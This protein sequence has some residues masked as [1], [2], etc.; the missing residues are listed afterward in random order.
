MVDFFSQL[1]YNEQLPEVRHDPESTALR[2]AL[3]RWLHAPDRRDSDT[4][5]IY[6]SGHGDTQAGYF[7]L[8]TADT[9][10]REYE[11][12]AFPADCVL[13]ELGEVPP[14][15]RLLLI[16][17]ACYA[18]Q[19][20]FEAIRV[21]S[22]MASYQNLDA[23]DEGVWVVAAASPKQEAEERQ[24]VDAFIEAAE[25][26]RQDTSPRQAFVGLEVLIART[27][28]ILKSRGKPQRANWAPGSLARGLAPFIP[29]PAYD[30][31]TPVNVDLETRDWLRTQAAEIADHWD[32]KARGVEVAAQAGWYFTGRA[33][34]LRELSGW[35]T[36]PAADPRLRVVTGDPG[37]GKSAVL[38]RLVTLANPGSVPAS[39]SEAY[40]SIEPAAGGIACALLA[41]G[42]TAGDLIG[43]LRAALNVA[44]DAEVADALQ[45]R[46][47]FAVVIDA[48]DEASD[49]RS[50]IDMLISPLNGAAS[51][52]AGPRLV[53]AARRHFLE[54]L[55][56]DRITVDLDSPAYY[57]ATD[58]EEYVVKLLLAEDNPEYP[59]H[60]RGQRQLA[61]AAASEIAT[62]ADRS[63][64][65]AQTAARTLA[66]NP[67]QLSVGEIMESREQWRA[68]GTAFD[69]DL[70]R[71]GNESHRVRDLL[72]PLAYARGAGLP[73]QL[74]AP[75]AT[76]LGDGEPR[77]DQDISWLLGCAGC[78]LVEA[79]D[80]DEAVYRLFH[81]QFATHLRSGRDFADAERSITTELLRQVPVTADGRP[82]WLAAAT[83][84]RTHLATHAAA[85]GMLDQLVSDP[86]FLL[87]ADPARLLPAL[88][89][90]TG[91]EARRSAS[92]FEGAQ[93]VLRDRPVGEAAAQLDLAARIHGATTL[94]HGIS[95]LPVRRPW[96]IAWGY[97][98]PT[99][100]HIMLGRHEGAVTALAAG[101]LDDTP[102]GVSG[103]E[104]GTVRVWD[105]RARS[106]RGQPLA[107][108]EGP[109]L[110]VAAG[111]VEGV[112]VAVS[113][114]DDGTIRVWDLRSAAAREAPSN[115]GKG[116]VRSVAIGQI[117]GTP[118]A[119]SVHGKRTLRVWDLTP[120]ARRGTSLLPNTFA[121][122][123]VAMGEVDGV[124]VAIWGD[125][126]G[127]VTV[128]DL[129]AG[130]A[131]GRR[132]A[133]D[134]PVK[135]VALGEVG[136]APVVV[137]GEP[138]GV[139]VWDL[140]THKAISHAWQE[141][142]VRLLH[143]I[144]LTTGLGGYT[145]AVAASDVDGVPVAVSGDL[146]GR[147][148]VRDLGSGMVRGDPFSGHTGK[149][150]SVAASLVDGVPV[151]VSGGT[152][153]TVRVWDLRNTAAP[154]RQPTD[155]KA[156]CAV[157][158]GEAGG[159]PVA[160]T[161]GADGTVRVWDLRTGVAY[162]APLAD[163]D[164]S[165]A[166]S[167]VPLAHS[168]QV[169]AVAA[170]SVD[171]VPVAV[172]ADVNGTVR[173]WNLITGAALGR[174]L[175]RKRRSRRAWRRSRS[176]V[177]WLQD[178][179]VA[180]GEVDGT[181]VAVGSVF[182]RDVRV[183]DL[184]TGAPL[185]R[186]LH[187][188]HGG[189]V[190]A[191][192]IGQADGTPVAIS[193]DEYGFVRV[194]DMRTGALQGSLAHGS[195]PNA[196]NAVA[197]GEA[198]G[199][200]I[201]VTAHEDCSV[202]V[203]DLRSGVLLSKPFTGHS[204]VIKATAIG[205]VDDVPLVVTGDD[206]GVILMRALSPSPYRLARLDAPAGVN[207][208]AYGGRSG[209]IVATSRGRSIWHTHAEIG[210][211]FVWSPTTD[212]NARSP[213]L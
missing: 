65:I 97:W 98:A 167:G 73:R 41:T 90:V 53:I 96:T 32:P 17:D 168:D 6:Y 114:G 141:D 158:T 165:D 203:W 139:Q 183:W 89:H 202:C 137:C 88:I 40:G 102:I 200:P 188:R 91:P 28:A 35:L 49:P 106:A 108:H 61:E 54:S 177:G 155:L 196:I 138:M 185:G 152:D 132:F 79:L 172:T 37:S 57:E 100:R 197:I 94:A 105:L 187:A 193:G 199:A 205:P 25:Q 173:A 133:Q 151:A 160:V 8:L 121:V 118:V 46:P 78:Y 211:L 81:D 206:H 119:V 29:N 14:V 161:G 169:W 144:D 52:G 69:R 153:G 13:K 103:G 15:R 181:P 146:E 59:T 182:D 149:V 194:W 4:A 134:S 23:D 210:S 126:K 147:V 175:L 125:S 55:P 178:V 195:F 180:V 66:R 80:Q 191:L 198:D 82:Q 124:P 95:Q 58:I 93:H 30:P 117:D 63:F 50:V 209:W 130:R 208:I 22:R 10:Q 92:A 64:L 107:G 192:A 109:V 2:A 136:G 115:A 164:L 184:R 38:G 84:T 154:K 189:L 127:Y 19:G 3:S 201:A 162:R 174:P 99:D 31:D 186:P 76:A 159:V 45:A 62:A 86:M 9:R 142:P 70:M 72:T 60:Y 166:V 16:F 123:A 51:H 129:R 47:A 67:R 120:G 145:T 27:N 1:G 83:Y 143:D 131:H 111:E 77:S 101:T 21:A 74:W 113:G 163:P 33:A 71:Y 170:G 110:A 11:A 43:E 156:V 12:T 112:P 44:P 176:L 24:F 207:S 48:L 116:P 150:T 128:W 5:V 135:G 56:P 68:V 42:K 148:W 204:G 36:D 39:L 34:A 213:E 157:A 212:S 122:N 7:Y 171:G 18:G 85:A 104:D 190:S 75:L 179:A 20:A 140:R 87:A 26:L